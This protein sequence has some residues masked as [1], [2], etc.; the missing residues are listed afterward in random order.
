MNSLI[1]L[2]LDN[3]SI[4]SCLI[5]SNLSISVSDSSSHRLGSVI[6]ISLKHVKRNSV[7]KPLLL[8]LLKVIRHLFELRLVSTFSS[9]FALL[10]VVLKRPF[11]HSFW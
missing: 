1:L 7:V 9:H 6:S 5:E 8:S 10:T 11:S 3:S 4:I 2:R